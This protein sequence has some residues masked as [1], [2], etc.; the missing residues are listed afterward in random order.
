[1]TLSL[2]QKFELKAMDVELN[3]MSPGQLRDLAKLM[4]TQIMEQR[5]HF[6]SCLGMDPLQPQESRG[7]K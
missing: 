6:I 2:E 1:M 7:N 4:M 5:N 3:K